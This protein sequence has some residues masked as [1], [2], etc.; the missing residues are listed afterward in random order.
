MNLDNYFW[1]DKYLKVLIANTTA[2]PQIGGVENSLRYI[3]RELIRMGH[4]VKIF[5]FKVSSNEPLRMNHDS[6]EII[7]CPYTQAR[8]PHSQFIN[9]VKATQQGI[10][11]VLKDFQPDVI[12]SRSA[13]VGVGIRRSGYKGPLL[14]IFCTNAKMNCRGLFLQTQG[15][16]LKRRLMLLSLWPSAYWVSSRLE[17]EL[18]RQCQAVAFSDNMRRQLVHSFPKGVR[19]CQVISPGVDSNFFSPQ[20]GTRYLD[21]IKLKFGLNKEEPIVLYVGRL[22]CAK[23]IPILMKAVA[24]LKTP[25]KIV[26]VG[27][28]PEENR[29]R[30]FAYNLGLSHRTIFAGLQNDM[31]PGFYAISRVCV[32]PTTTE[33]FGQVFLESLASGT[34]AIGFAG[35]GHR[36]LTATAEIIRDGI[37]GGVVRKVNFLALAE[38]IDSILTIGDEDY[39]AMSQI[40]RRDICERFSWSRFVKQALSLSY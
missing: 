35:D 22:S 39:A 20:N 25:A 28:G 31:L 30:D 11:R 1:V 23:R 14:Q 21:Q 4:E 18:T 13:P 2:Y 15:L 32:L 9:A 8:W 12:W 19:H 17:R 33:S 29:L 7:R 26:I 38:K 5:C 24:A 3:S 40:A 37:T 36:V 6:V 34:P 10:P 16:S 27:E